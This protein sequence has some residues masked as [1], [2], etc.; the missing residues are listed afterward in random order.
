MKVHELIKELMK[1]TPECQ[2]SEVVVYDNEWGDLNRVLKVQTIAARHSVS[3]RREPETGDFYEYWYREED[4][5][6]VPGTRNT[7]ELEGTQ[8]SVV[9][10]KVSPSD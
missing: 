2:D 8:S 10:L 6:E 5:R 1:L 4:C 3:D 9:E 7:L